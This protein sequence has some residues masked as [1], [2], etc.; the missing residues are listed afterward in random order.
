MVAVD[1]RTVSFNL[2]QPGTCELKVPLA[3]DTG[4][5]I[6]ADGWGYILAYHKGTLRCVYETISTDVGPKSSEGIPCVG[7]VGTESAYQRLN[8]A[9]PSA[10]PY[11]FPASAG[12]AGSALA[13]AIAAN[14]QWGVGNGT[15]G[16]TPSVNPS[17]FEAG[18]NWLSIIQAFA[19]RGSGFDFRFNPVFTVG[20][21]YVTVGNFYAATTIGTAKPDAKFEFGAGTRANLVDYS[22]KRLGGEHLA[23]ICFVP[24]A[25]SSDENAVGVKVAVD[26]PGVA[27]YGARAAWIP[28]ENVERADLRQE[29]ANDHLLYRKQPRRVL[30]ITPNVDDGSGYVPRPFVDYGIGDSVPVTIKDEGIEI[31]SG[32]VRVYGLKFTIDKDGK[33]NIALETSPET[34]A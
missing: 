18:S 12:Q 16:T 4:A 2:N 27:V 30:S 14:N 34:A 10:S 19:F 11:T 17:V 1:D 3:S 20:A 28:P 23:P 33:E 8:A 22:W 6:A 21:G 26:L 15:P 24:P 13:T 31:V 9:V 32:N 7:V 5:A 29:L 25:G